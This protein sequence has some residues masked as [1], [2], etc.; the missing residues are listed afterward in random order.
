VHL[1]ATGATALRVRGGEIAIADQA[2]RPV[3]FVESLATRPLEARRGTLFRPEWRRTAA[4]PRGDVLDLPPGDL[5]ET[6]HLRP[7]DVPG[8]HYSM[9]EEHAETTAEAIR[10]W[11]SLRAPE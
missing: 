11:L 1:L 5:H 3:A 7:G 2:G 8:D 4:A 9:L 6:L 10:N